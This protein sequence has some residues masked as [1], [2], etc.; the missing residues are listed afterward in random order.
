VEAI[1]CETC[2]ERGRRRP[3]THLELRM[4][5]DCFSGKPFSHDEL[6]GEVPPQGKRRSVRD[7]TP[8]QRERQREAWRRWKQRNREAVNAANRE[9]KRLR[10]LLGTI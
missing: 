4:C 10:R 5:H 6:L 9:R 3:A 1:L 8:D 7:L 2:L